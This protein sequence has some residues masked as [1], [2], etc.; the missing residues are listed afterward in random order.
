MEENSLIKGVYYQFG[1]NLGLNNKSKP[2]VF[3]KKLLIISYCNIKNTNKFFYKKTL[4]KI[5]CSVEILI[6]LLS[7]LPHPCFR[8]VWESIFS[9]ALVSKDEILFCSDQDLKFCQ[10]HLKLCCSLKC[11]KCQVQ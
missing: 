1:G 7:F 3:C 10:F 6:S 4:Q 2:Y 9:L 8:Q 11:Q 5:P